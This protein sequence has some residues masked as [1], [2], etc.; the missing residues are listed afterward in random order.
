MSN[1]QRFGMML[2]AARK[3]AQFAKISDF[4]TF[5]QHAG[6]NYSISAVQSWETGSRIPDRATLLAVCACLDNAQ[7]FEDLRQIEAVLMCAGYNALSENEVRIHFARLLRNEIPDAQL[8]PRPDYRQLYGRQEAIEHVSAALTD[9]SAKPL[10]VISGL[11]GIGKT[12]LA[13]EVL[14]NTLRQ[15]TF[16]GLIWAVTKQEEFVGTSTQF[17]VNP[18]TVQTVLAE[19][20]VRIGLPELANQPTSV[21]QAKLKSALAERRMLV[22]V[23]NL[24]TL[25]ARDFARI[26]YELVRDQRQ[27]RILITSRESLAELPFVQDYPLTG[28]DEESAIALLYSEAIDRRATALLTVDTALLKR[29][30][31][32]TQGMPL[33]LK[34]IVTQFLLSIPVDQE[35]DRLEST[36]PEQDF[37][38]F[39]YAT[40]WRKLP[41]EAR[42]LLLALAAY[43]GWTLRSL[44]QPLSELADEMFNQ[45]MSELV[46][47]SLVYHSYHTRAAQQMYDI[48]AMTRWFINGP[49]TDQWL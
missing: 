48:H 6:M 49:L 5:L 23:D 33:A 18:A 46:R 8:P 44:L 34:L 35:L 20:G 41:D 11:G 26:L 45:A 4:A 42:T 19:L 38:H 29:I 16:Q 28:L 40:V 22:Y 10:I 27:S 2:R 1:R 31:K 15:S 24:E 43:P 21:V 30:Y 32:V 36:A 39:L 37:Y 12:A 3:R 9:S 47:A 14:T 17:L 7:G 25:A 13:Y